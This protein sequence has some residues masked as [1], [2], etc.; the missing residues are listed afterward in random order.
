V[1]WTASQSKTQLEA[2]LAYADHGVPVIPCNW[3]AEQQPD[4]T[5]KVNKRPL[6]PD[7]IYGATI[8][9]EQIRNWWRQWPKA[10]IGVPGGRRVGFWY[11]DVDAK[12]AHAGDGIGAW[13][14]LEME[15]SPAPTRTH[16]TGTEG[17]HH[18]FAWDANRPV[19]CPARTAI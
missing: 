18:V 4:G 6:N 12:E 7:G 5:F 13:L 11:L 16:V 19:G 3:L 10:L 17:N 8:D 9:S 2:A 14:K 15:N 1:V